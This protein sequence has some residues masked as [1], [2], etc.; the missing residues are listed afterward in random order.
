[1]VLQEMGLVLLLIVLNGIFAMAEFAVVSSRTERLQQSAREGHT[2]AQRALRLASD[3]DRFLSTV[4]IGVSLVGVFAGAVGGATLSAPVAAWLK[5]FPALAPHAQTIALVTVVIGITY[6]QLVLGELVPKRIALT[7]PERAA[8]VLSWPMHAL[9]SIMRPA[10]RLLG[11]STNLVLKVLRIEHFERPPVTEEEIRA[12][13]QQGTD[14]GVIDVVEQDMVESVFLLNDRTASS[15]MTPRPE[16]VWLDLDDSPEQLRQ[17]IVAAPFSR[18]PVGRESLEQLLGEVKAKDLL[19]QAWNDEPFDLGPVL[20]PPLYVPNIMPALTVL[21]QFK[22]SGTQLAMVIDEYGSVEGVLT[23]TDI[24][25]AIVGDIPAKDQPEEPQIVER[26][27]GSWL[28]DG[29]LTTDDFRRHW[30]IETLLPGEAQGM[31]QTLAGFA[32]MQLGR[33]P[34]SA[35]HFVWDGLRF[36][37]VDMDGPRIDKL[38]I[39]K[40]PLGE[41]EAAPENGPAENEDD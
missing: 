19:I 16:V 32:M 36:E 21:E 34:E 5:R 39:S 33:V 8:S 30:E 41:G 25:E 27:D 2:G 40:V 4:Q 29:M 22:L 13:L 35:D 6:L 24:L 37:I 1:M 3:L 12:M 28:V 7:N 14:A 10:V 20:H 31:F 11:W 9:S 15:L 17:E 26:D 38:L 23:L 18:F